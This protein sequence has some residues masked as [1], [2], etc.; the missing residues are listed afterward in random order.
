ME[1]IPKYSLRISKAKNKRSIICLGSLMLRKSARKNNSPK[2]KIK[3]KKP[4]DH[5]SIIMKETNI[6]GW[7]N[8]S[9]LKKMILSNSSDKIEAKCITSITK[10]GKKIS[11]LLFIDL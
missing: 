9:R 3:T 7:D 11:D 2:Q 6:L 5:I 8:K 4:T 1:N 10:I